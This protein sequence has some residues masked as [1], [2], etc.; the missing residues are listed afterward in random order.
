MTDKS[1]AIQPSK[2]TFT[3]VVEST[4]PGKGDLVAIDAEFISL[5]KEEAQ[6]RSSGRKA[7]EK[8]AHMAVARISLVAGSGPLENKVICDDYL[9]NLEHVED[10]LTRYSGIQPGD[11]DVATSTKHLT[12]LKAAYAKVRPLRHEE[13]CKLS[14]PVTP[15]GP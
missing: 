8:P 13:N 12:T 2:P 5:Q 10:Y 14:L 4:L 11:L 15:P 3:R 6:I 7:T 9:R 1:L